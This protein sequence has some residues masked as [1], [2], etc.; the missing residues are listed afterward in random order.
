VVADLDGD[1]VVEIVAGGGYGT[2]A[3]YEWKNGA[4]TIKNGWPVTAL[5]L[6][7]VSQAEVRG[8]GSG[9]SRR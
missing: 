2:V 4:L 9:R 5:T 1:G 7:K 6:P 8:N 3:A